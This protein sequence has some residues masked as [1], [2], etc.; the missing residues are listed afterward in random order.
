MKVEIN[1]INVGELENGI[2]QTMYNN[3]PVRVSNMQLVE[4]A[5][6]V[7]EYVIRFLEEEKED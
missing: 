5:H 6:I 2:R 3:F 1:N 7:R 4:V